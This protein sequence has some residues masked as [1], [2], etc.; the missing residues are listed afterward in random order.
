MS[1]KQ[2]KQATEE[3]S[4]K[5]LKQEDDTSVGDGQPAENEPDSAEDTAKTEPPK[6]GEESVEALKVRLQ[7]AE[8]ERDNYKTGM[9]SAKAKTRTIDISEEDKEPDIQEEKILATIYRVNE[10]KVLRDVIDPKSPNY[11]PELVDDANYN[12]IVG[13]LPYNL[14]KSTEDGIAKGLKIAVHGWKIAKGITDNNAYE[15]GVNDGKTKAKIAE[16]AAVGGEGSGKVQVKK[17]VGVRK[18]LK[19]SEPVGSWYK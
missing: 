3:H 11:L 2:T 9:L 16:L 14:D 4:E 17:P 12:E 13:Y 7:K 18:L 1:F 15:K 8:E 10:K 19:K 6:E 5:D